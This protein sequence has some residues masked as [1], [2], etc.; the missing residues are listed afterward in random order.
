MW[1]VCVRIDFT[2]MREGIGSP[3][4]LLSDD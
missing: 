4:P 1:L 2:E 3:L